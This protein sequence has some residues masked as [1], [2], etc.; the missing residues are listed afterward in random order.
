[1]LTKNFSLHEFACNDE[2]GTPVPQKYLANVKLLAKNLQ[3]LRDFLGQPLFLNS[4]YRTKAYNT[5]VEGK[6]NSQ[7]LIALAADVTCKSKTPKQLKS[8]VEK[9]IKAGDMDEGGLGLYPGFLH[10]DA[11]GTKARW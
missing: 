7:H 3:A 8:I 11:R 6:D 5:K 2:A 10:Y 9:L 1:M 4:G